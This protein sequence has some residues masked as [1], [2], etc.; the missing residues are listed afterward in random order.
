MANS[1]TEQYAKKIEPL[2][3]ELFGSS[4]ELRD[5]ID[6]PSHQKLIAFY[7]P[8][9]DMSKWS[10]LI[11]VH[12]NISPDEEGKDSLDFMAHIFNNSQK[13]IRGEHDNQQNGRNTEL[14]DYKVETVKINEDDIAG[15]VLLHQYF[16]S[17]GGI[18]NQV[19]AGVI[20]EDED[21]NFVTFQISRRDI[22]KL[23][24]D[25]YAKLRE[26]YDRELDKVKKRKT[27]KKSINNTKPQ[28]IMVYGEPPQ[29]WVD[30]M[31]DQCQP[32]VKRLGDYQLRVVQAHHEQNLIFGAFH[33]ETEEP[34]SWKNMV[35]FQIQGVPE[36]PIEAYQHANRIIMHNKDILSGEDE[37]YQKNPDYKAEVYN[38]EVL[39]R[40]LGTE[41]KDAAISMRYHS[42]FTDGKVDEIVCGIMYCTGQHLITLEIRKRDGEKATNEQYETLM[43]ILS[44]TTGQLTN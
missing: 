8:G 35:I 24:E 18:P 2:V 6:E 29:G 31:I 25:Q 15:Q 42:R 27:A 13:I 20:Y 33:L 3:H 36:D 28:E 5:I 37:E 16:Q 41:N 43:E 9:E 4:F 26:L 38:M 30:T 34:E 10:T 17:G 1:Y 44:E 11:T 19:N 12:L 40:D 7:P 22:E 32:M 39:A 21:H 14:I 23:P